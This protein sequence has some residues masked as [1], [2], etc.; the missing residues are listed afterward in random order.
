MQIGRDGCARFGGYAMP[1]MTTIDLS[2]IP[3][4]WFVGWKMDTAAHNK[5]NVR[6]VDDSAIY[7]NNSSQGERPRKLLSEGYAQISSDNLKLEVTVD[8]ANDIKFQQFWNPVTNSDNAIVAHGYNLFLE[9]AKDQD[10]NDLVVTMY[11]SKSG[12]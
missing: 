2:R 10:F 1:A 7:V 6:L 12:V 9:D 11:A 4:G 8:G 5:I 3:R